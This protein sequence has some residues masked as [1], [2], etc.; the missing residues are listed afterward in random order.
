M[1]AFVAAGAVPLLLCIPATALVA[2]KSLDRAPLVPGS[3]YSAADITDYYTTVN[4]GRARAVAAKHAAVLVGLERLAADTPPGARIMWVRPEYVALLGHRAGVPN[5]ALWD[6]PR[7]AREV[8]DSATGFIVLAGMYKADLDQQASDV[9]ALQ[10]EVAAY[11]KPRA[12]IANAVTG[13]DEYMLME[14]VPHALETYLAA[15]ARQP[16]AK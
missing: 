6:G 12:V 2:R 10:R 8:R 9:A 4:I 3:G 11:A 1:L 7:L 13:D 16:A 14:V 5:Y 15:A